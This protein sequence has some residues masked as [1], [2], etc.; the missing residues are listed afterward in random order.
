MSG[1]NCTSVVRAGFDALAARLH[2]I[3]TNQQSGVA[4]DF[5]SARN[6]ERDGRF[7]PRNANVQLFDAQRAKVFLVAAR[8]D[9]PTFSL[10][11]T[12][13]LDPVV[14]ALAK[15]EAFSKVFEAASAISPGKWSKYPS[16]K[17]ALLAA[18]PDS[19]R[20]RVS[21]LDDPGVQRRQGY[22]VLP[23]VGDDCAVFVSATAASRTLDGKKPYPVIV[24]SSKDM[25]RFK[26]GLAETHE[27]AGSA[28]RALAAR[29][30]DG[31]P[32]HAKWKALQEASAPGR[33]TLINDSTSHV[34]RGLDPDKSKLLL[35]GHGGT[36]SDGLWFKRGE[37]GAWF[38]NDEIAK[39]F[40][41]AK[42]RP[43][44]KDVRLH[45]CFGA[46]SHEGR[47]SNAELLARA[48]GRVGFTNAEV[49]GYLGE[50]GCSGDPADDG[51]RHRTVLVGEARTPIR[52]SEA[53][54]TFRY[55]GEREPLAK[56][57]A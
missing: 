17:A 42:L 8:L 56:P 39:Q 9:N 31:S 47:Q 20:A 25:V 51:K 22:Y 1:L 19:H 33:I 53:R 27:K 52:A 2:P 43:D 48:L 7:P 55:E 35:P 40:T 5:A 16:A 37:G 18:A 49:S 21:A 38:S 28:L 6:V 3:R 50:F 11:K 10:F 12:S 46:N 36:G 15:G 34:L 4:S 26:A 14:K 32:E 30:L 45:T 24:F 41:Y 29:G 13:S 54:R 44:F 23:T 57:A